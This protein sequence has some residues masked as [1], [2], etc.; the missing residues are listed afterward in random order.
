MT[1]PL[2][3]ATLSA[4]ARRLRHA[5]A[6]APD[7]VLAKVVAVFDSLPDR[8]EA[9]ALLDAA[10]PRLRR[11]RPPRPIAFARLLFLPLDGVIVEPRAWRRQDGSLPRT[12]LLP[13]SA[14]LRAA[15]GPAAQEIQA[16]ISGR[17]FADLAA[18][19]VQGRRL[20][21]L[22]AQAAPGLA[23]PAGWA[24][25]GL[26]AEDFR[27]AASLAAGVWRQADPVWAALAVA[28]DGPP[29]DLLR[30][31]LTGA[32]GEGPGVLAAVLA[33]LMQKA[34]TPGSVAA[35]A[36]G[37][38]GAPPTL[39]DQV[40]DQWLDSCSP[41]IPAA[42]P[43]GAARMAEEFLEAFED[44]ERSAMA[45]RAERRQ[46]IAAIRRQAAEACRSAY[47]DTAASA[48]IA[49]LMVTQSPPDDA[50]IQGLEGTARHLRRLEQAG[51]G[52][53]GASAFDTAVRR[54]VDQFGALRGAP[55]TNPADL[56]RL[57]EIIAGPEAA[58]RLL[59]G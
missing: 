37:L 4:E 22:A 55:G 30:P 27:H 15:I 13:F 12:A 24:E 17:T 28:R 25:A 49:P 52:L 42:D 20:W 56:V 19:D 29:E 45:R 7:A 51:R 5:V 48:L 50:T 10:R 6:A 59:D 11:L 40:L 57:A 38:P 21:R 58:L 41:E 32:A 46:R 54:M 16:G 36:A 34:A 1:G 18:I 8:R 35:I 53:G 31:A 23:L 39:A 26:G 3:A 2:D 44:L 47:A 33:T 14:A 9:D 43:L